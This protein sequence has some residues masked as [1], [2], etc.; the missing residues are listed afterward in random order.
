[1]RLSDNTRG[2]I[3]MNVAMLA[4][5]LNDSLVK[6][7]TATLPLFQAIALRG[8]VATAALL[9]LA[10]MSGALVVPRG[11]ALV[12]LSLRTLAEIGGTVFFLGALTQMPLANLSAIMQSMPLAVTLAAAIIFRERV[13][14]AQLAAILIGMGGV[15]LIIRPGTQGFDVWSVMGLASVAC[16]VVRDLA[17]RVMPTSLPSVTV[18]VAASAGVM[19]TGIAVTLVQGWQP[20]SLQ[21]FGLVSGAAAFLVV[22]YLFVVK[23]MRVGSIAVIAPF[24]YT[25]LLWALVLGWVIFGTFPDHLT[26]LGAGII[27][28][29][30]LF[31]L[32]HGS[33]QRPGAVVRPESRPIGVKPGR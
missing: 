2:A 19:L 20:V 3:Y 12:A 29:T 32:Y 28:A 8:A 33:R 24:R 15:L 18:A 27:V 4:F 14:P 11:Q 7:V 21:Q 6:A 25:A 31:T 5:T 26:L 13:S 10:A 23:M 16:V 22:G 1:M 30:G 17:T 9:A